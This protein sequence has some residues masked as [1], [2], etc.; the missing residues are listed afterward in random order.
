MVPEYPHS[1]SNA[2][3]SAAL[4][5]KLQACLIT[6]QAITQIEQSHS[7]WANI[8]LAAQIPA[9]VLFFMMKCNR[10]TSRLNRLSLGFGLNY[11]LIFRLLPKTWLSQMASLWL[12]D[13]HHC[14]QFNP[15]FPGQPN[16]SSLHQHSTWYQVSC[17]FQGW[18][19]L[20][21][22]DDQQAFSDLAASVSQSRCFVLFY[23]RKIK[24]PLTWTIWT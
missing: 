6:L 9:I 1:C 14:L 7:N 5:G 3:V 10:E 11:E 12:S 21:M 22:I 13:I 4:F 17:F 20:V 24:L 8:W 18:D 23:I 16:L 19:P 15:D 2:N